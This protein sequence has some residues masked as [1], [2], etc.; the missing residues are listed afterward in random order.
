MMLGITGILVGLVSFTL[1]LASITS[2]GQP[3]FRIYRGEYSPTN[4]KQRKS[5]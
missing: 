3:Y 5:S 2:F 4:Y 1:Y